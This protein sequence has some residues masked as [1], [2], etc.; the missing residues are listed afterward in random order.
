MDFNKVYEATHSL[1]APL[2][3]V[4]DGLPV[5]EGTLNVKSKTDKAVVREPKSGLPYLS[6]YASKILDILDRLRARDNTAKEDDHNFSQNLPEFYVT[7]TTIINNHIHKLRSDFSI[8]GKYFKVTYET[9][10]THY[11]KDPGHIY[12]GEILK[13]LCNK[14]S[15]PFMIARYNKGLDLFLNMKIDDK[16]VLTGCKFDS[17]LELEDIKTIFGWDT[18]KED[19]KTP[20]ELLSNVEYINWAALTNDKTK[21]IFE[22]LIDWDSSPKANKKP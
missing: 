12:T 1:D 2:Q 10:R 22:T 15:N 18:L 7:D 4:E 13:D 20:K 16:W 17:D 5:R 19:G 21:A 3:S 6:H 8:Q 11:R 14:I 9:L